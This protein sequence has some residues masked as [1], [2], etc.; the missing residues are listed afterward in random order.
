M[1]KLKDLSDPNPLIRALAMRTMGYINVDKMQQCLCEYLRQGFK[2]SDAY[3]RK[4]AVLA[5]VK[6]YAANSK[7]VDAEGFVHNLTDLLSDTNST[8]YINIVVLILGGGHYMCGVDRNLWP[9]WWK[10]TCFGSDDREQGPHSYERLQW[11]YVMYLF[12]YSDGV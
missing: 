9:R 10:E 8:V 2:D 1:R 12:W 3:V 11:V 6:L 7:L 5:V 4:T